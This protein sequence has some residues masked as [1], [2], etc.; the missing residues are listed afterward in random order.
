MLTSEELVSLLILLNGVNNTMSRALW[1]TGLL[2]WTIML[3][4]CSTVIP[5]SASNNQGD[6]QR[7]IVFDA[8]GIEFINP[9]DARVLSNG[10]K[11]KGA[12]DGSNIYLEANSGKLTMLFN[13]RVLSS[14]YRLTSEI[15]AKNPMPVNDG[16]KIVYTSNRSVSDQMQEEPFSLYM[17]NID[18]SHEQM[19]LDGS[20]FGSVRLIDTISNQVFAATDDSSVVI[21]D[22][23]TQETKK[24]K[25]EGYADAISKD[26]KYILYRAYKD[27]YI[28]PELWIYNIADRTSKYIGAMPNHYFVGSSM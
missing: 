26:G 25:L 24:Y 19:L 17:I 1:I 6:A 12:H 27:G 23:S 21:V 11:V 13:K 7:T 20:K 28:L 4:G 5:I 18:G 2:I 10:S 8:F 22:I 3:S 15:R 9:F 16:K 14:N